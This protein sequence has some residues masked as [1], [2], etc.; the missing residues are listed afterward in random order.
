[1]SNSTSTFDKLFNNKILQS[2]QRGL[3]MTIPV[4][5]MGSFSLI[6]TTLPIPAYQDFI[7]SFFNG[8]I[9]T[10]FMFIYNVTFGLLSV[11]ITL[12]I[13]YSIAQQNTSNLMKAQHIECISTSLI[14]LMIFNG[15]NDTNFNLSALNAAGMFTAIFS[16]VYTSYTLIYLNKVI[17]LPHNIYF[18]GSDQNFDTALFFTIPIFIVVFIAA[19]INLTIVK[20]FHLSGFQALF[21]HLTHYIFHNMGRSIFSGLLFIL[22]SGIMWLC[23]IHGSD[24]LESVALNL[25]A[26]A[27]DIN[28][29]TVSNGSIPT[30]IFTKS[31]FDVF[32]FMG[33]CGATLSL[34]LSILIFSKRRNTKRLSKLAILPMLFNINEMMVF[35][36]PIVFNPTF[37]IPFL[38]T[39]VIFA[40]TTYIAMY[41]NLVPLITSPVEWTTPVLYSGYVATGSVNAGILQFIN[42][43]IG[44]FIYRPFILLFDRDHLSVAHKNVDYMTQILQKKSTDEEIPIFSSLNTTIGSTAKMLIIDL[45]HDIEKQNIN[46]HYQPQ[47]DYNNNCIGIEA[48]LRWK[49]SQCGD[50]FPPLVLHLANEANILE[51][52]ECTIFDKVIN[53][54]PHIQ[55]QLGKNIKVSI[56]VTASTIQSENFIQYL[57]SK[58]E[59]PIVQNS[60]ICIEIT[61]QT[62]FSL[63]DKMANNF[64]QIKAM[65]YKIAID[66][67]SM[68]HTS[69]RYLQSNN[70]DIVKLDGS[71]V[72]DIL[73]N[74]RC[75][76]IIS[77]IIYLSQSLDFIV[78]A[79]YVETI[80]QKEKLYSLGCEYYQGALYSMAVPIDKLKI[81]KHP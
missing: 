4:L 11:Y 76:D 75:S 22:S 7:H 5:L 62:M 32:V 73:T 56:N 46:L 71:L 81:N 68:G 3:I 55:S 15:Y 78:I 17:R 40:I 72:R 34:A 60:N 58:S 59:E 57:Q 21:L 26:P 9:Y 25:Y 16:A 19:I 64:S 70:F 30:E 79:E 36:L 8:A 42:I 63:D 54:L 35:G 52:L 44:I 10:F 37:L 49:D 47:F 28:M 51:K 2:I 48:L 6:C 24:V 80:E 74:T 13:S 31:F 65:G 66:D 53:D 45:K 33:G 1:M 18:D 43:C 23:G 29:S 77:S 14:V 67:F 27:L 69:L 61:E 12:N 39:P 41:F 38:I 20:V 50:I